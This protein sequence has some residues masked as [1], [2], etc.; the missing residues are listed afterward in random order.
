MAKT[1]TINVEH[2][3]QSR[4]DKET[5]REALAW[6]EKNMSGEDEETGEEAGPAYEPGDLIVYAVRRLRAL[7]RDGRRHKAGKLA[8]HLYAPRLDNVQRAPKKLAALVETVH[9]VG[10]KLAP[11]RPAAK[12]KA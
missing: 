10:E 12:G 7:H 11:K 1:I 2:A 6:L 8:A 4:G 9:E 5:V 3:F